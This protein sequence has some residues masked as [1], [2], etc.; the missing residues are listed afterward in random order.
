MIVVEWSSNDTG[1]RERKRG[2][3]VGELDVGVG[4][5]VL[6]WPRT[7][8]CCRSFAVLCIQTYTFKRLYTDTRQVSL[9]QTR[10]STGCSNCQTKANTS[11]KSFFVIVSF[12]LSFRFSN[13]SFKKAIQLQRH[14]NYFVLIPYRNVPAERH[15]TIPTAC[16][17]SCRLPLR[18]GQCIWI[19]RRD[20]KLRNSLFQYKKVIFFHMTNSLHE[21]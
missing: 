20:T 18:A 13:S 7:W 4:W 15:E 2:E 16:A 12:R 14:S 3:R 10:P 6:R 9:L 8:L 5:N 11:R 19:Y 1:Q 17:T 21:K